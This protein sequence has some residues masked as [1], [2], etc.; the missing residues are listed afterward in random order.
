MQPCVIT[1]QCSWS[2]IAIRSYHLSSN[3]CHTEL[4]KLFP[5]TTSQYSL[6]KPNSL[7]ALRRKI[8][9]DK[10]TY[11]G[12]YK[13]KWKISKMNLLFGRNSLHKAASSACLKWLKIMGP[14]VVSIKLN[15]HSLLYRLRALY[16]SFM[17]L[18]F[19]QFSKSP[20]LVVKQTAICKQIYCRTRPKHSVFVGI[21]IIKRH[22]SSVQKQKIGTSVCMN[23]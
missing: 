11:K 2:N 4:W 5:N 6:I 15:W 19:L 1:R 23:C 17:D 9:Y 12:N 20:A 14:S 3:I 22:T 10:I 7:I 21:W 13:Y 18:E 8:V 16:A